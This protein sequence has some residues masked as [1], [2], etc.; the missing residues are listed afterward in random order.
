MFD[1]NAI[2]QNFSRAA[3][4]YDKNAFLQKTVRTQA[5]ELASEYFPK[6]A[7]VLDV[8]CGTASLSQEKKDWNVVGIDISYGMCMV[9]RDKNDKIINADASNLP[10]QDKSFDCVF[11]SLVLQWADKPETIIKEILRVLKPDGIA[12]VTTFVHGTLCELEAA[13]ASVDNAR[14][15][16][17]FVEAPQLLL[18][19]AHIGGMVLEASEKTYIEYYD[20]VISLMR[21]IKHIGA[22]NKLSGRRK[23]LM[24]PSQLAKIQNAYKPIDGQF[25]AH[26]SVLIMV[27]GKS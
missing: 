15:I 12:V 14:H 25:Q 27:I 24:T 8:G 6:K 16:T 7:T 13:F 9:A 21:S 18:Q 2:K 5:I 26:W 17:P 11:S 4:E 23:G 3:A 19:V 1:K 20:D 22:S 10:F